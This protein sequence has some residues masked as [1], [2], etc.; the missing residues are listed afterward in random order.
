MPQ[1]WSSGR[2]RLKKSRAVC[3]LSAAPPLT[4]KRS[5]PP[6]AWCTW[7]EDQ[8]ADVYAGQPL[9]QPHAALPGL[10]LSPGV[11]RLGARQHVAVDDVEE[12]RHAEEDRRLVLLQPVADAP[13][14]VLD[15]EVGA[16]QRRQHH[17]GDERH[18]VVQRQH[19][20]SGIAR[21][22]VK[23]LAPRRERWRGSCGG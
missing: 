23:R 1:P 19:E 5:L 11:P 9:D 18:R 10:Q 2:P 17:G 15:D 3:G 22:E 20:Q 13:Q 7:P 12:R 6:S 16:D 8:R 14:V 4:R 21:A